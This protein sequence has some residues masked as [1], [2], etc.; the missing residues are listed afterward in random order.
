[1]SERIVRG[2]SY[3]RTTANTA[4]DGQTFVVDAESAEEAERGYWRER[5]LGNSVVV[6][7]WVCD[8]EPEM[9][10]GEAIASRYAGMRARDWHRARSRS[11]RTR[12][13]IR[14]PHRIK[15]HPQPPKLYRPCEQDVP[16]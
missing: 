1:V 9:D 5:D 12:S 6:V 13:R 7:E 4:R 14:R 10:A 15:R 16:K 2:M 8:D 3:V 11:C